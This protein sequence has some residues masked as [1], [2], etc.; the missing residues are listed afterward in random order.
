[1][2]IS[3]HPAVT[4]N[5]FNLSQQASPILDN[6]KLVYRRE[7][8]LLAIA[9]TISV[10]FWLAIVI[11]TLGIALIYAG[12]FYVFYLFV[13]S[14]L[15]AHLKGNAV[16]L[17]PEQFPDLYQR[18]EHC[19]R[20]LNMDVPE[21]Y[22]LH[23]NGIFN[24]F[25]T[26]FLGRNFVVLLS[27]MVDAMEDRPGAINFYMGHELG[28]IRRKHLIY[29]PL[30]APALV[31]PLLGAAYSRAREYSSDLHGLA[32]CEHVEDATCGL[33][34]LAAGHR[35]WSSINLD[36]YVAQARESGGFWMSFHELTGDYPYLVKRLKN[37]QAAPKPAT[38]PSRSFFAWVLAFFV[39]RLGSAAGGA[40]PLMVVAIIGVLAA[41]GFP[42]YQDFTARTKTITAL[43]IGEGATKSLTNF[44]NSNGHMPADLQEAGVGALPAAS[45][46]K[47]MTLEQG[48]YVVVKFNDAM[49]A[50]RGH[51]I[52]FSPETDDSHQ[53]ITGWRCQSDVE[54][55]LLP[56]KCRAD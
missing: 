7:S 40:A 13:H 39:P 41:V 53:Q 12:L 46:I 8:A 34:A 20:R 43:Q 5:E 9:M 24:A 29:G 28:H 32:C 35:R 45:G 44:Y 26:R 52:V 14:A 11:G 38:F 49:P 16:R 3:D 30:L 42:A 19:A 1:M 21:A 23:G 2:E 51:Q 18:L 54:S 55:K 25:A 6:A 48:E 47:S 36:S 22:L 56:Q 10:L 50:L 33:A 27:D 31:L 17:T 37:I 15:I 4:P